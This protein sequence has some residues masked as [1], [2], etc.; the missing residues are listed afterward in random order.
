LKGDTVVKHNKFE[1]I[2][3]IQFDICA[4]V[5]VAKSKEYATDDRLH[6]FKQAAQLQGET[7]KAALYGMMAKH[8]ISLSD[9]CMSG[10]TY[11]MEMWVEKIT[12]NLNY[13]LLLKAIVVEELASE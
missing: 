7:P 13:L 5:L 1:E 12:D 8:V 3:Q 6:N 11:P 9:M 2:L 10:K 4:S